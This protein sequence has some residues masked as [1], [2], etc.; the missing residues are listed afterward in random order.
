MRIFFVKADVVVVV[1]V[2][3]RR[4]VTVRCWRA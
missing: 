1:V 4:R 2:F 3:S